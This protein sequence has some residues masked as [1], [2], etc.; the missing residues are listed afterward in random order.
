MAN[1]TNPFSPYF[2]IGELNAAQASP[3]AKDKLLLLVKYIL[4]PVRAKFGPVAVTSA[5]RSPEHNQEL[6]S[7]G[8]HS[9]NTSQHVLGE[10]ADFVIHGVKMLDVYNYIKDNLTYGEL[11]Y[12]KIKGHCHVSLP[13]YSLSAAGKLDTGILDE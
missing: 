8:Y 11:F 4:E 7:M 12:Y 1:P 9:S 10:A 6:G 13:N 2:S 5:Y 3:E